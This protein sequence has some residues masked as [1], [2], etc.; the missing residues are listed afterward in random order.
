MMIGLLH[1]LWNPSHHVIKGSGT[2]W[3]DG[4]EHPRQEVPAHAEGKTLEDL[5][6]TEGPKRKL[7][8]GPP[9]G[10]KSH[11]QVPAAIE[12]ATGH[13]TRVV[14]DETEADGQV[15]LAM[16]VTDGHRKTINVQMEL[17]PVHSLDHAAL[18]VTHRHRHHNSV[19]V[20]LTLVLG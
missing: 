15:V 2:P 13:G 4:L 20:D 8:F 5:I 18:C 7:V 19:D 3:F 10:K 17:T 9:F 14:E 11:D 1:R 16:K 12:L 6:V